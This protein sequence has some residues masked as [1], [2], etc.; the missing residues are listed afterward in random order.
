VG[1]NPK[2]VEV[3]TLPPLLLE[4][5]SRHGHHALDIVELVDRAAA[6]DDSHGLNRFNHQN[7]GSV[8]LAETWLKLAENTVLAELL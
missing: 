8:R 5:S 7:H 4:R 6:L 3:D 2:K 1:V